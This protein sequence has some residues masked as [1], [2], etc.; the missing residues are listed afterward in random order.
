MGRLSTPHSFVLAHSRVCDP[1]GLAGVDGLTHMSGGT[2]WPLPGPLIP[3]ASHP[4]GAYP[5]HCYVRT[6]WPREQGL[7]SEVTTFLL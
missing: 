4:P 2:C 7:A 6:K 3:R 5:E 1:L